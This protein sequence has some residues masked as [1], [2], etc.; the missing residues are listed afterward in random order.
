MSIDRFAINAS[1]LI[2]LYRAQLDWLLPKLFQ[3]DIVPDAVWLEV[4]NRTHDDL[5]ARKLPTATWAI[6]QPVVLRAEV[7]AW[8][9]GAGET[10]L[11]SLGISEKGIKTILDDRS[12][13][14]CAR[15]LGIST[16][17]TA[18]V[19]VLAKRRGL[20]PSVEQA[21]RQLQAS[22]A[23]ISETLIEQLAAEDTRNRLS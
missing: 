13:R 2:T 10:A 9:L 14:H 17:G 19:L 6:R 22:G 11:L 16:M 8:N 18:G 1:P 4:V 15:V 21:L 7:T 23:W 20:I 3:H 12:A 5:V